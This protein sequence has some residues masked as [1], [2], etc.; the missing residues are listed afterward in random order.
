VLFPFFSSFWTIAYVNRNRCSWENWL[1]RWFNCLPTVV[2]SSWWLHYQ[3]WVAHSYS[4]ASKATHCPNHPKWSSRHITSASRQ[5]HSNRC[6]DLLS[7]SP[8]QSGWGPFCQ[9]VGAWR[10]NDGRHLRKYELLT[11]VERSSSEALDSRIAVILS[12]HNWDY[13]EQDSW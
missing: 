6:W 12:E 5:C 1:F 9:E 3:R 2:R 8:I 7:A 13:S 11:A 4:R 10:W